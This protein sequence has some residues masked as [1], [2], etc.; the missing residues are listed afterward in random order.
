MFI[1]YTWRV[2]NINKSIPG[3]FFEVKNRKIGNG[4]VMSDIGFNEVVQ[5]KTIT[6]FVKDTDLPR[7]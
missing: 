3:N 5:N 6:L 2:G 4:N 1:V 7:E